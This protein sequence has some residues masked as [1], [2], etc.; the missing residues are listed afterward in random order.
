MTTRF[1]ETLGLHAQ[2]LVLRGQRNAVLASNIANAATP[3]FKARDVDFAAQLASAARGGG[4]ARTS[5][6]HLSGNR[7]ADGALGYRVPVSPSLD[8]NTVDLSVEQMEFSEN[9]VRY[10]TSLSFLNR[11]IQGLM[12]AIR[13]E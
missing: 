7:T 5:A 9:T 12:T 10:Q 13:G 6:A 11:R 1:S 8:G 2:A 3:N 4:L